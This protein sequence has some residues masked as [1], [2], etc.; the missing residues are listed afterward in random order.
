MLRSVDDAHHERRSTGAEGSTRSAVGM[1]PAPWLALDEG[2]WMAC[3]GT[4]A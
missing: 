1:G 3:L 2:N 4:L